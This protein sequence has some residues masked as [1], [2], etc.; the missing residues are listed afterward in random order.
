MSAELV[1][2]VK[3]AAR[4][5][6]LTFSEWLAQAAAHRLKLDAG[7]RAIAE[8]ERENGALT[9]EEVAQGL[10]WARRSLGRDAATDTP[11]ERVLRIIHIKSD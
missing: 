10:A 6:G 7:R 8:W 4:A 3:E 9:A 1:Q 5:E 2:A 11:G